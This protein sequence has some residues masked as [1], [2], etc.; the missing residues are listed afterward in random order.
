MSMSEQSTV[1]QPAA[2]SSLNLIIVLGLIAMMSGFLVVLTVQLTAAR[3]AANEQ[4][5]L[6]RAI[7]TVLPEATQSRSY[8][9]SGDGLTLLAEGEK[10]SDEKQAVYA[11]Y[12]AEGNLTGVAMV[13]GARGYQDIVKTLYGYSLETECVTGFTVLLSTETPGL[14]DKISTDADFQANFECLDAQLNAD[15]SA[16]AHPI[17]TVK[18][19]TKTDPWQIDAISGATVTSTAVGNGLRE[20]TMRML[21]QLAKHKASL[22]ITLTD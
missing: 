13:A 20:S 15:G 11:G 17:H 1:P 22:P 19:G 6:E 16:V 18:N 8:I 3:I 5:A 21:P 10:V 4:A 7:F 14:G 12:D 9:L 2:P